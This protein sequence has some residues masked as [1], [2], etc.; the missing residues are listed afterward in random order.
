MIRVGWRIIRLISDNRAL[1]KR[2][3][4]ILF[5]KRFRDNSIGHGLMRSVSMLAHLFG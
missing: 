4:F 2:Q 3:V 1:L 5:C